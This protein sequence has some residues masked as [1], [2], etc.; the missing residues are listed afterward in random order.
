LTRQLHLA[1][2]HLSLPQAVELSAH[3]PL[4]DL[5]PLEFGERSLK[6]LEDSVADQAKGGQYNTFAALAANP[7][8]CR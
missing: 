6:A 2:G 5:G 4:D 8:A 3:H 1:A 7:T